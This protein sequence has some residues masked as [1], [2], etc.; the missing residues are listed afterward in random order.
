MFPISLQRWEKS[1]WKQH[2][3]ASWAKRMLC[4]RHFKMA[5]H[6]GSS[7]CC[8][9]AALNQPLWSECPF[10]GNLISSHKPLYSPPL[11]EVTCTSS[12]GW[13]DRGKRDHRTHTPQRVKNSERAPGPCC[14]TQ[15]QRKGRSLFLP[16]KRPETNAIFLPRS[17]GQQP[18][19]HS[20]CVTPLWIQK[21]ATH[22]LTFFTRNLNNRTIGKPELYH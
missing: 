21:D 14:V 8:F 5:C 9:P 10:Q 3:Q 17:P 11:M 20:T 13:G 15:E 2:K 6:L 1:N 16:P 4:R 19:N 22:K 12:E 7:L 18:P